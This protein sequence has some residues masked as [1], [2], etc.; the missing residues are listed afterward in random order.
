[1]TKGMSNFDRNNKKKIQAAWATDDPNHPIAAALLDALDEFRPRLRSLWDI[2]KTPKLLCI[3]HG[4]TAFDEVVMELAI[5][6]TGQET[7]QTMEIR[8]LPGTRKGHCMFALLDGNLKMSMTEKAWQEYE[9]EALTSGETVQ[10][11]LENKMQELTK[12]M[13]G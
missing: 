2:N 6:K 3:Q 10:E 1:M 8:W 12:R 13:F 11:L 7:G 9:Q 4:E 5:W